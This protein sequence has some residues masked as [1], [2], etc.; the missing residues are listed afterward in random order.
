[1][2]TPRFT[3]ESSL[4]KSTV[5]Y[6]GTVR[7]TGGWGSATS[8]VLAAAGC[9]QRLGPRCGT[10]CIAGHG[11]YKLHGQAKLDCIVTCYECCDLIS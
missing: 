4:F 6:A 7:S 9:N 5:S 10:D 8:L 1:M 11:C 3:G 2:S